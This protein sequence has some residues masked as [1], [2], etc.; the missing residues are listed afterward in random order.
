MIFASARVSMKLDIS[1]SNTKLIFLSRKW[2]HSDWQRCPA[3]LEKSRYLRWNKTKP[4]SKETLENRCWQGRIKKLNW[5]KK[6]PLSVGKTD[7]CQKRN[8]SKVIKTVIVRV[9]IKTVPSWE[10][11]KTIAVC[12]EKWKRQLLTKKKTIVSWG[13]I[14]TA[15]SWCKIKKMQSLIREN[16]KNEKQHSLE[17]IK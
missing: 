3:E 7:F 12:G 13:V 2:C 16:R 4:L 1:D 5:N 10:K 8:K 9:E 15:V 11:V 17:R 6:Q 14:K